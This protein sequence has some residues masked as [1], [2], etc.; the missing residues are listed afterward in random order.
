MLPTLLPL[1]A[2]RIHQLCSFLYKGMHYAHSVYTTHTSCNPPT[3]TV[4]QP[5]LVQH[6]PSHGPRCLHPH[7]PHPPFA[8]IS[9]A[10]SF[11]PNRSLP[12]VPCFPV[13]TGISQTVISQSSR[14]PPTHVSD[15]RRSRSPGQAV[16]GR[17]RQVSAW[18]VQGTGG[19]GE[20]AR[21]KPFW[22][23]PRLLPPVFALRRRQ[24][25][26][27]G[28]FR[29]CGTGYFWHH[30][31]YPILPFKGRPNLAVLLIHVPE[32]RGA[33]TAV[34]LISAAVSPSRHPTRP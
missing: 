33:R 16:R 34:L 4:L 12:P 11:R 15:R 13:R 10:R 21:E 19:S 8:K 14:F 32:Q 27:G 25:I 24:K 9:P 18:P 31:P 7:A 29:S 22:L 28:P 26:L 20:L 23:S 6:R 2:S 17:D 1:C 5:W 3:H 30:A